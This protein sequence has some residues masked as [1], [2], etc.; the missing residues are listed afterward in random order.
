MFENSS[1]WQRLKR[2]KPKVIQMQ[3]GHVPELPP[4]DEDRGSLRIAAAIAVVLHLVLFAV[5]IPERAYKPNW[6]QG[7][8]KVFVVQQV[9]FEPPPPQA[10][11]QLA[12]PK[13]KKKMIP[14]PDKTPEEPEPIRLEELE[15]PDFDT[16]L[17]DTTALFGIPEGPPTA[18]G[19][20]GNPLAVGGEVTPPERVY[21][22]P[23]PY[24]EDARQGRVEG[25]V[26]LEA[27]IDASGAVHSVKI[28]KGLPLGL[29]ESAVD[30]VR[31]WTFEP[32]TRNGAPVAVFFNL[33]VRFSLQ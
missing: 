25:V 8:Q 16:D 29:A 17:V 31:Q 30:T 4:E 11:Q 2:D 9:R 28:L 21:S 22:P 26:I 7:E 19:T 14:V 23:P 24:T 3:L 10:Q 12:K 1:S 32:A 5:V 18:S 13:T 20:A 27:I 33:T 6:K 15:V